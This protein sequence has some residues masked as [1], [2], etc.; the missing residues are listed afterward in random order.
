MTNKVIVVTR[1]LPWAEKVIHKVVVFNEDEI[2]KKGYDVPE[3]PVYS[4]IYKDIDEFKRKFIEFNSAQF[5]IKEINPDSVM[6]IS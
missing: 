4:C 2:R 1:K 5:E 3:E 6:C